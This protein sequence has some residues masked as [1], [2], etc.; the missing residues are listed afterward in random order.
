MVEVFNS[1]LL[2]VGL[3]LSTLSYKLT[4]IADMKPFELTRFLYSQY[5]QGNLNILY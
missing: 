5:Y 1:F 4:I 3:Y 2:S